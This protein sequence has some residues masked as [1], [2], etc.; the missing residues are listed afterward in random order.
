MANKSPS[1]MVSARTRVS[2]SILLGVIAGIAVGLTTQ[3]RYVPLAAWDVAGLVYIVWVWL[4]VLPMTTAAT[5]AHALREDPGRVSSHVILITASL[6]SLLAV[7]LLIAQPAGGTGMSQAAVALLGLVSV[8][9]GW[10]VIHTTFALKY[11]AL[12][13][14]NPEGGIDFNQ[15]QPPK[16]SDFAYVAFTMGMTFQV[17][18]TAIKSSKIRSNILR[19][20]LLAYVFGTIIVATTINAVINLTQ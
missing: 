5:K 17:S 14:G 8:I 19:Q 15:N 3:W 18:D 11:A 10:A 4:T 7:G 6:I 1:Q 20:G 16:Y 2:W 12:Y 9:I 13:Y